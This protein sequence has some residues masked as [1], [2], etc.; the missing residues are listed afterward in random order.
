MQEQKS[1]N[2]FSLFIIKTFQSLLFEKF[3][4]K[5]EKSTVDRD[6]QIKRKR[7]REAFNGN[8][9]QKTL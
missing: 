7:E 1:N 8:P 9:L 5:L 2:T 6:R 3:N 4:K